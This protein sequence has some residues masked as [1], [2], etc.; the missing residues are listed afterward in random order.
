MGEPTAPE[1][2][3]PEL[4][5]PALYVFR[6]VTRRSSDA[7]ERVRRHVEAVVGPLPDDAV[8]ERDSSRGT[9][10]AVHVACLLQ[11]ET[12]RREI[13]ARLKGDG[14]VVFML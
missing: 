3:L 4:E 1:P 9:Y 7:A 14:E 13:Y 5:Y 10:L 8:T 2:T 12:Q 6:A 11:S